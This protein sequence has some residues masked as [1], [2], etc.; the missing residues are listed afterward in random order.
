MVSLNDNFAFGVFD[1][2]AGETSC[3][4]LLQAFDFFTAVRKL[5]YPHTR[6]LTAVYT[7]VSL[8][9]NQFLG[10]VYQTSGQVTGVGGTKSCIGQ[11][12]TCTMG[13]HEVFQYVQTFTEVGLDGQLDSM[14]CCI[15]HQTTHTGQ[16]F[17]LFIRTT[18]TGIGHHEDIVVFI[19]T[20][21]QLMGQRIIG[22]FPGLND[23]FITFF[24]CDQ[25]TFVVS[26]DLI[27]SILC[28]LDQ[29]RFFRRHG[30]IGNGYGHGCSCG[31][32]IT[33]SLDII[34]Y[35]CCLGSTVG[36]DNLFQDLFQL[37]LTYMEIDL[38]LQRVL[39]DG[40]IHEAQILRQDLIEQKASQRSLNH[41]RNLTALKGAL[42]TDHDL[43][44]QRNASILISQNS[45]IDTIKI[46][47]NQ[48]LNG[49]DNDTVTLR[50]NVN[51]DN[52]MNVDR[53]ITFGLAVS[54]LFL[55]CTEGF[56]C[57]ID[58]IKLGNHIF[59]QLC[60]GIISIFAHGQIVDTKNHIL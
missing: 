57:F 54:S 26:G 2:V 45:L 27:Y 46:V 20:G 15:S 11:T 50:I 52:G 17:D 31:V 5:F 47:A 33:G 48:I 49:A 16:L 38:R 55:M 6:D 8:T 21:Q 3:D 23:L 24:V 14:T 51:T 32:V 39:F 36:I 42:T 25:T 53:R 19:Q 28:L 56:Q 35:L 44:V 13:G 9:D 10:N 40:T 7:T 22:L 29:L 58:R 34:Q 1:G 43:L 4:T 37:F 30:H 12:L 18:G 41:L 59:F 60:A